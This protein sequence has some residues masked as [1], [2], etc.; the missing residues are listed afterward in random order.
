MNGARAV[1]LDLYDAAI[2]AANP[3][4]AVRRALLTLDLA[5]VRDVHVIALGKAAHE[6][7]AGAL[8]G[9]AERGREPAGGLVVAA[10]RFSSPHP[11]LVTLPGD[12]PV[13]GARS[14]DAAIAVG[15]AVER[16]RDGDLAL[17]LVSGGTTS[18][19]GAPVEG[20]AP[21][22][23]ARR[24]AALLGSGLDIVAMNAERRRISRWAAG[25]LGTALAARGARVL[26]LLASDVP[27]DDPATI[28]SGPCA[29]EAHA[30]AS[31]RERVAL[32]VVVR[33]SAARDGAIA[34]AERLGLDVR[35]A[36]WRLAGEAR[37][38]GARIAA[39]LVALRDAGT[40][41]GDTV[42]VWAGETTVS[43]PTTGGHG[44]GGRSQE[45]ALSAARSL[46]AAEGAGR[47]IAL[48]AAGT[49][50]RDGPTAA[51]GAIV[52]Q[53]TWLE[54]AARGRDPD[55]DLARHDSHAALAAASA[56]LLARHTGANA[57]DIAIGLLAR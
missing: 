23:Y 45:L 28:G 39:E 52:T 37:D 53:D 56:L 51:A 25:R 34:R 30:S 6:M 27:G 57:A 43:L 49:D 17:V 21:D 22:E 55:G 26:C 1:L 36:S 48:L 11:R 24:C 40:S 12:H 41:S 33:E 19:V 44:E 42:L 50:G 8:A 10:H 9:L 31:L 2:E 3:A 7:A 16:V 13:P 5:R 4:V 35:A 29:P 15:T 18:L 14:L 47:G 46:L 32:R 20:M 38:A 54:I